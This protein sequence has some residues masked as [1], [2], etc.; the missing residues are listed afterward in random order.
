VDYCQGLVLPMSIHL[1]TVVAA[2]V[3]QEEAGT[4]PTIR[5]FS[6]QAAESG[7]CVIKLDDGEIF[8]IVLQIYFFLF[9]ATSV[10]R[11]RNPKAEEN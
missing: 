8:H 3:R 6:V 10:L 11:I 1:G 2:R 9:I 7:V 5:V 4:V